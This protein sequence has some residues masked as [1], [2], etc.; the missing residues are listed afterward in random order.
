VGPKLANA[1]EIANDDHAR[2]NA[3]T[4]PHG[5]LGTRSEGPDR[6]TQF[7][8]RADSLLGVVFVRR[9]IAEKDEDRIPVTAGDEAVVGT[10]R[11]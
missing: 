8:P 1:D 2:R 5:H 6:R 9:R 3:D 10:D 7:E 11:V 4:T